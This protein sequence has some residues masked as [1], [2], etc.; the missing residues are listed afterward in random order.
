VLFMRMYR[1]GRSRRS[2][3][4]SLWPRGTLYPQRLALSSPTRG[5][6]SV[7]IVRSRTRTPEFVLFIVACALVTVDEHGIPNTRTSSERVNVS[8]LYWHHPVLPNIA[9]ILSCRIE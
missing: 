5:G 2:K 9:D 1:L 3:D 7:G 6:R 8:C 4:T